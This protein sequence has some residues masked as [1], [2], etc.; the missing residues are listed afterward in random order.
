MKAIVC[1]AKDEPT[2][3]EWIEYHLNLGFT[4]IYIYA[5]DWKYECYNPYHYPFVTVIDWPGKVKQLA[6]YNHFLKNYLFEWA[7]FIDVDEYI[8]VPA[9]LD[10]LLQGNKAIAL[11][12][13]IYGNKES[14]GRTVVERFRHWAPDPNRHVKI[15][16]PFGT[17]GSFNNPHFWTGPMV[18]PDG[19]IHQGPF[20][21][22]D[23]QAAWIRHYYYQ[24]K[25]H[26]ERKIARGRADMLKGR[27][28]N[29][30]DGFKFNVYE[31]T[32]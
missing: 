25:Q 16:C 29:W 4:H 24:D 14:E 30:Q 23:R 19:A 20:T 9:G 2:I 3:D 1:I 13:R 17:Y 7:A 18:T 31:E 12:W 27:T 28:E 15:I 10:K 5:N 11:P 26:W 21:K 6:A 32:I 22:N 8:V